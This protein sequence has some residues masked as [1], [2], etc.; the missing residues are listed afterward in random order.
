MEQKDFKI[1]KIKLNDTIDIIEK[2]I[3]KEQKDMS[4]LYDGAICN[5]EE[6]IKRAEAVRNHIRNLKTSLDKPYFA[7]VDFKA[8]D[9]EEKK[10]IYIGKNG[11]ILDGDIV[12]TDWRAPISSLYYDADLGECHF[13]APE[14][15]I[16]GD[17]SLKRQF[18]IELGNLINYFDI[19]L[20]S[21]DVL[22]Q[23]YL[24]SNND[25]RLKSIV[26][27]I[28]K[29]QNEVIRKQMFKNLIV[30]GV[31]G[32]G[33]TT[34]ALHRIAYLVY[35]YLKTVKQSQYL[36]IG[37]NPVFIKYI[38]SVLPDLDVSG[39]EQ[40]T[41][42]QFTKAYINEDITITS[43]EKK[44]NDNISG[45]MK[46][47]IDKFKCSIKYKSMIDRFLDIFYKSLTNEDLKIG[48]F[49]VLEKD[50]VNEVFEKVNNTSKSSLSNKIE[51]TIELLMSYIEDNNEAI[52]SR[53][54]D[55][56]CEIFE[57]SPVEERDNLRNKFAK[58]KNEIRKNCKTILKKYF[59]KSKITTTKLYKIFLNS[60]IEIDIY[61]YPH[62]KEL[63][64]RALSNVKN[65]T[66]DFEDLSALIYIKKNLD[67]PKE[68][69]SIKH[70][71]IDEAQ[72][73][74]EFNFIVLKTVM[75]NAT[76]SIFGD[77]AQSIYDYRSI[78][79]WNEVNH[80]MFGNN[81]EIINFNKSY[82]TTREIMNTADVVAESIGLT[83]SD[84]VIRHGEPVKFTK[85]EDKSV[86]TYIV[87]KVSEY[88]AKGY[89]TIA[90]ISKT[91]L[92]SCSINNELKKVGLD[93][94]D[95]NIND[96]LTDEKFRICTITNQLSK[97][98]E[99][100]AVIINNVS[101]EIYNSSN[102]L[103][104]KLLYVAITRALHELDIVYSGTLS[105]PLETLLDKKNEHQLIKQKK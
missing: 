56:S 15:I 22:L 54:T 104:M 32:S 58:E 70:V 8:I 44:A 77:L 60:I 80:C 84:L 79:N 38:K 17:L 20:V 3:D 51:K 29:E 50:Y 67:S 37:P 49:I 53:Y 2:V 26:S 64:K 96:D 45:K 16:E 100:D 31:A 30:Q 66:F 92:L 89:K 12:V 102:S 93:I 55:Y 68:F 105:K 59:S 101:E 98:L 42:E 6:L 5:K 71:V 87:N 18:E 94:P 103:D 13:E 19:D 69:D 23:K 86:A 73:L 21:N 40:S 85:V 39:V 63:K 76:F 24:N 1:E 97:G 95:V 57:N 9:E 81:G 78:N 83:S 48:D 34:V 33:K 25:T 28:Q 82:R 91:N 41:F 62:I 11:V 75:P 36:V 4:D 10:S 61:K 65:N 46:N 14:G 35:N 47:D 43:S 27:T 99:F 7:R 90:I 52:I 74:G 88:K 72:D